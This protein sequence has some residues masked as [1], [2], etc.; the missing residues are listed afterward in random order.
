[1]NNINMAGMHAAN[2]ALGGMPL[3]NNGSNGGMSRADVDPEGTQAYEMKAKLNTYIYEYFLKNELYECARAIKQSQVPI[4]LDTTKSSPGRRRDGD[5]NGVDDNSMDT[6]SKDDLDSKRPDDLPPPKVPSNVT[7]N[8]F[9]LDWFQL[10]WDHYGAQ[11]KFKNAT[12]QAVQYVQNTQQQARLRQEQQQQAMLRQ[13]PMQGGV[14]NYPM[15]RGF[16]ANGIPMN[17]ND[18][19]R[20]ILQNTRNAPAHLTQMQK[21]QL[22]QHAMMQQMQ[23]EGSDIDI[24]GQRPR[25]PSLSDN[26]PSPSKRPRLD[27]APFNA[28]QIMANGRIP[29]QGL[30][31]QQITNNPSTIHANNLLMQN[32]INPSTL[33]EVQ[34]QSF[35]QQNPQ[36]Q[37][38]SIQVYAQNLAHHQRSAMSNQNMAKGIP[39]Q[40]G[41]PNHGSPMMQSGPDGVAGMTDYYPGNPAVMRGVQ[42]SNGQNG[43]HA[44]QDYQQQLQLL[45]QQNRKRLLMARQE[46]E[47]KDS[48]PRPDGQ[49]AMAGQPGFPPGTGMSPQGSRSGPSPNPNDQMARGTPKMGQTGL[50]VSPLPDGSMP[51][52]RS[53]PAPMM[54]FNSQMSPE[55]F[56][57]MKTMG[58]GMGGLQ[59]P[60]GTGMRPPSSHPGGFNAG[61]QYNPQ[62]EAIVRAQQQG[63]MTG[64]H[65]QQGAQGQAPMMQQTP[66]SQQPQQMGTPQQRNAMP[67]PQAPPAGAANNGR[68]A[69]PQQTAA[70]PTPQPANKQNPKSKKD[71]KEPRK[72]PTKKG[73]T[74]ALGTGAT[75]SS[76]AENPPPT[77]TPTTPITPIHPSSF[78]GQKNTNGQTSSQATSAPS[79][80]AAPIAPQQVDQNGVAPF[81]PMDSND[82]DLTFGAFDTGD[83][84][85][86]FDFDS[87][88]QNTDDQTFAFDAALSYGNGD[89]VEAGAG[90]G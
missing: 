23:R 43:N 7:A 22:Q 35:Q 59:Q 8:S 18:L 52:A 29:P 6:D 68:P 17:Q 2:G 76:E 15:M 64:G 50:P 19:Q 58:D 38:K 48:M 54:A 53:S 11:R 71:T 87:F 78:N 39:N 26:A 3:M 14:P 42:A 10:F 16:Q 66:Q 27:G 90:D 40:P 63:R 44:L 70:P 83:V 49:P 5:I 41:M 84:L 89:G 31:A 34:F 4:W 75:P 33:S 86:N 72:R 45:E 46:Q 85:E 21:T 47:G 80:S 62:V 20:K 37:Q 88:L 67:P 82:V 61:A 24:N 81:P 69:S 32:G 57:H 51:Q 1:M 73:S 9:L 56:Q 77:P 79:A 13:V 28:Q 36:V 12:S 25:T 60:N 65:W 74:S 30:Q 55:L